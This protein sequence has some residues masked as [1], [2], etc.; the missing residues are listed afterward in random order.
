[1]SFPLAEW[2]DGHAHCRHNLATSGMVG[3][4]PSPAP[5]AAEVRRADASEL[6]KRLAD[7]L[8][9]DDR[10]VFLTTGASQA[11]ALAL[12]FL[13][14]FRK[15]E[16]S[17]A[18]RFCP[19]EYPPLFDTARWAG[20]RLTEGEGTAQ[21]A[22]VSQPRNPEG[23][24]WDRAR[25]L[26]W[27]SGARSVLVDETFREFAG[28]RSLLGTDRPGLWATGSFTKFFAGDDLRVGFL[29]APEDRV[30][31]FARFHGLVTNPLAPFSI[32]GATRALRDREKIR[33]S[34]L[35]ILRANVAVA[36]ASFPKLRPPEGP[37]MFDRP[38][39]GEDGDALA[40]RALEA[41][42]LVCSGSFFRDPSGVR[43][44]LT[45][46]SFSADLAAYL[47]VRARAPNGRPPTKRSDRLTGRAARPLPGGS[48]RVKVSPS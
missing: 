44:C 13:A 41:S 8:A 40:H 3:A 16:S 1:M 4:T 32:A 20:F 6:R 31:E 38:E 42:V 23:D 14:R 35:A 26:D 43:L 34:V 11:N 17:R 39:S 33:R 12:L 46:R 9:V 36:H 25:F 47:A 45:R 30:P 22:L 37:V 5:S 24:L 29:V 28:T 2:I 48:G 21:V 27:A 18:C 7:D 19:P 10:R 15:G